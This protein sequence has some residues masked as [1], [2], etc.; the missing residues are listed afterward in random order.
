VV[1]AK[2]AK[3][4]WRIGRKF[5]REE[6]VIPYLDLEAAQQIPALVGDPE[7]VVSLRV[8]MPG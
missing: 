2:P 5:T 3:G 6:T 7:L 1:K 8:P 4:R